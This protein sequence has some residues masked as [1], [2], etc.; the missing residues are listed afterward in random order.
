M[1]KSKKAFKSSICGGQKGK[2]V[3]QKILAADNDVLYSL[4]AAIYKI[5]QQL[6]LSV[7]DVDIN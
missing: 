6:R 5:L 2:L 3:I 1:K 7:N 4:D